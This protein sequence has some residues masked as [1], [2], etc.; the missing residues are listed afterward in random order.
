MP[1]YEYACNQCGK[2]FEVFI[3][4]KD[5]APTTCSYCQSEDIR[6][7]ISNCSFQL[8]G[9]GWYLTDYA[10]KDTNSGNGGKKP[11]KEEASKPESPADKKS[12][13]AESKPAETP[14][15]KSPPAEKA[16]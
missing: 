6:K 13:P 16:A 9:T 7:L 15:K 2:S 10:R 14:S 1:I 5:S 8:K 12:E 4:A 11:E 3:G